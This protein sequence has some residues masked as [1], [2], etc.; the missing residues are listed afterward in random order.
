MVIKK[1]NYLASN[2]I[3]VLNKHV[4]I[5]FGIQDDKHANSHAII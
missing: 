2:L 5:I 1:S 4:V 3:I